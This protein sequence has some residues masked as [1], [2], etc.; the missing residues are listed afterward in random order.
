[1]SNKV[2]VAKKIRKYSRQQTEQFIDNIHNM[3][4]PIRFR[5]AYKIFVGRDIKNDTSV[6]LKRKN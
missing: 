4:F 6:H 2:K 1:M 5:F 3:P